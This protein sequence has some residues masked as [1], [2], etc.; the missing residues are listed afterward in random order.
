MSNKQEESESLGAGC[1]F[2]LLLIP[3]WLVVTYPWLLL[4]PIALLLFVI[5]GNRPKKVRRLHPPQTVA[6]TPATPA[7]RTIAARPPVRTITPA[8]PPKV[9]PGQ[10]K[11]APPD[12]IPK[13]REYDRY[14]ARTW[15]EEFEA[16][17]KKREQIRRPKQFRPS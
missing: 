15:D 7:P 12:F 9:I 1:V 13:D 8:P 6:P 16:L 17:I 14:L 5:L 11:P 10:S 4:L 2:W 3:V